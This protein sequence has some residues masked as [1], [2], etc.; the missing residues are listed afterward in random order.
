[1][2]NLGL[3]R[4]DDAVASKHPEPV[5]PSA[6]RCSFRGSFRTPF[7]G[8]CWWPWIGTARRAPARAQK[9]WGRRVLEHSPQHLCTRGWPPHTHVPCTH[10]WPSLSDLSKQLLPSLDAQKVRP[11]GAA[12]GVA[13]L[14][15]GS[16]KRGGH[17]AGEEQACLMH[18]WGWQLWGGGLG[19]LHFL[20]LICPF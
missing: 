12:P 2:V 9:T 17:R 5:R 16:E 7:S 6:C 18:V 4:V 3:S 14:L 15:Q 13:G 1:M 19:L 10:A 11:G 20:L 8:T